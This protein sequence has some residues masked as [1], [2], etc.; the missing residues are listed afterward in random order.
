[1]S[2]RTAENQPLGYYSSLLRQREMMMPGMEPEEMEQAA[3]GPYYGMGDM[4]QETF[5]KIRWG[6]R[7]A[8]PIWIVSGFLGDAFGNKAG[9]SVS[10]VTGTAIVAG[11]ATIAVKGDNFP[12]SGRF[13]YVG[14][15]GLAAIFTI[16]D[17]VNIFKK[18]ADS[19][20]F[21]TKLTKLS[22]A[23]APA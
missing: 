15:A 18:K 3:M 14:I 7:I 19:P 13:L 4:D 12:T 9:A 10:A 22:K 5:D 8:A 16:M 20:T 23:V 6:M 1:M 11:A 2:M 21:K 17:I